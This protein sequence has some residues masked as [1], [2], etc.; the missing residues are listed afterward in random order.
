MKVLNQIIIEGT[1]V[2]NVVAGKAV[3]NS[4]DEFCY[5]ETFGNVAE[6]FSKF[7]EAGREIRVIGKLKTGGVVLAEHIEFKKKEN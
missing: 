6:L 4:Q 5:V 2:T 1:L 7:G 3:M